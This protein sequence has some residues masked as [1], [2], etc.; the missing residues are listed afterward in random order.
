MKKLLVVLSL[1]LF[2][3]ANAVSAQCP[4]CKTA[5]KSNHNGGKATVGNGIN[6]G[7]LFLLAMPYVLVGSAGLV[8]YNARRKSKNA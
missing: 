6:N 5:L 4:M 8:W 1:V 2:L 3:S 7:I